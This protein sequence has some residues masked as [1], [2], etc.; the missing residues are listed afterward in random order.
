MDC[1]VEVHRPRLFFMKRCNGSFSTYFLVASK[2]EEFILTQ[3]THASHQKI[4]ASLC[5]KTLITSHFFGISSSKK[6]SHSEMAQSGIT[7]YNN[8]PL[9]SLIHS[10]L[11]WHTHPWLKWTSLFL[12]VAL[13]NMDGSLKLSFCYSVSPSPTYSL[14]NRD[15]ITGT[16]LRLYPFDMTPEGY[17]RT[18]QELGES[19]G[20]PFAPIPDPPQSGSS[21]ISCRAM[22]CRPK[23]TLEERDGT[24]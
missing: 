14:P 20:I 3:P 21:L 7:W 18:S 19:R 1:P 24:G 5:Q 10:P 16:K 9:F 2:G 6:G 13:V 4:V 8:C 17:P 22:P 15:K 23:G 12:C 11:M